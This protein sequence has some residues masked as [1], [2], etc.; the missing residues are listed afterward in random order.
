MDGTPLLIDPSNVERV[1]VI[2]APRP[3]SRIGSHRRRTITKKGADKPIQG[4]AS[5]AYNGASTVLPNPC[6][7]AMN[8]SGHRVSG[9]QRSGTCARLTAAPNTFR[10]K[11]GSAFL[12]YDFPTSSRSAAGWTA[13]CSIHSGSMEPGYENCRGRP[14]AAAR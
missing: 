6:R 3:C 13:S 2:K 7:L 11:E 10:Q 9:S 4:E 14:Q 12:S 5:V 1:E 8:G